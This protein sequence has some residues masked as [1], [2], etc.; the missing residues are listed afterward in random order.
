V[1]EFEEQSKNNLTT[2]VID[3]EPDFSTSILGKRKQPE[4]Y[5]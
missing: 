5:N 2:R 3:F 1:I 4:P